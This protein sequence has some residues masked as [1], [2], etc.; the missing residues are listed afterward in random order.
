MARR[1]E[2]GRTTAAALLRPLGG[3]RRMGHARLA[4][5]CLALVCLAA[6]VCACTEVYAAPWEVAAYGLTD[7]AMAL[8]VFNQYDADRDGFL[9]FREAR[10]LQADT[11][12]GLLLT[13]R[14]YRA[15]QRIL[16]TRRP[17]RFEHLLRTYEE[18]LRG[19]L[20]TDAARDFGKVF[21]LVSRAVRC[22]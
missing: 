8:F 21:A 6:L 17:L 12:P 1:G 10:E 15:L 4:H 3:R 14:D 13:P 2:D 18:P 9:S 19:Q 7:Y 20:G 5:A 11:E 22:Q 16:G